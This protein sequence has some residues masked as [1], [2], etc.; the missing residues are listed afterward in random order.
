MATVE[1]LEAEGKL[2]KVRG[3]LGAGEVPFREIYLLPQASA[4]MRDTMPGLE[5][6]GFKE[7]AVRPD[8]QAYVL[9]KDFVAGTDLF[10]QDM[11]PKPLRPDDIE[12]GVWELRTADLRF[13]GWFVRK[14]CFVVSSVETKRRILEHGLVPGHR[15]QA[16]HRREELDLDEPKY[17]K[18]RTKDVF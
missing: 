10:A 13:F 1:Q 5:T 17:L 3:L 18:G 2:E 8:Q 9:F 6:D 7:G 16:V 11:F 14:G 12:H 4:W 15:A